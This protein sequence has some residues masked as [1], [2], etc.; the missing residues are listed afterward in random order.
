[1][2]NDPSS[3]ASSPDMPHPVQQV[4]WYE[5]VLYANLLSVQQGL[6]VCYYADD[7]LTTPIDVTNYTS[8]SVYCDWSANGYRLP[9]EGEWEYFCRAGTTTTFSVVEPNFTECVNYMS[10]VLPNLESVAWF[11]ANR[12][13]S[14]GNNSTKPVG[15]KNAN[16]WGLYDVHGN[17][18]EW[19]WD[20]YDSSYPSG[21]ATDYLG[22][23]SGTNRVIRGGGWPDEP[24]NCRSAVRK[25]RHPDS[26]S[27]YGFR[28]CRSVD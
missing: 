26:T 7:A 21:S 8:G 4:T 28:L 16:P 25:S 14:L 5:A 9:S 24:Y 27:N 1:M 23:T 3:T 6:N 17:V 2:P 15:M 18:W 12:Y 20:R 10:G 19:C 13:D 11:N 22:P